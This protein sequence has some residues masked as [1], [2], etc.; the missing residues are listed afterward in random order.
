MCV[1][2][3][4]W[5]RDDGLLNASGAPIQAAVNSATAGETIFVWNGS[6]TENV[7][8]TKQITLRGE[9][10]DE[11]TV[12]AAS[13]SNHIF[14]VTADYVNIS[15]FT[16]TGATGTGKAGI[17]LRNRKHC[18]ISENSCSNNYWGICLYDSS[19]DN[20]LLGNNVSLNSHYGIRILE[21]SNNTLL[22]NTVHSNSDYGIHLSYSSDNTLLDNTV[23]SNDGGIYLRSLSN[24]NTLTSNDVSSNDEYGIN[25]CG[26]CNNTVV[27]NTVSN[28]RFGIVMYT[29]CNN[30]ML[31][32]NSCSN[33]TYNGIGLL[34]LNNTCVDNNCSNNGCG[35]DV[36]HSSSSTATGNIVLN[37]IDGIDVSYSSNNTLTNNTANLNSH[38]GIEMTSSINNTLVNNT[39]NSNTAYGIYLQSSSNNTLTSNDFSDNKYGIYLPGSSS[40]TLAN[41][42]VNSN[43]Y[44]GIYL[45]YSSNYNLVYNNYFNNANNAYDD[46]I[47][48]WNITKT[49][50]TNIIG[51]PFLGGNY[52]SDY[53]GV[54]NTGDGLGDTMLPYSSAGKIQNSGDYHPLVPVAI[55]CD[56]DIYVNEFGWWRDGGTFTISDAPIQAAVD[57]ANAGEKICVAAGNY[58]ENVNVNKQL[59][60]AGECA[61]RVT[62]I[63]ADSADHVFF[64]TAGSVNISGFTA[65]GTGF[66]KA[67]IYLDNQTFL[68]RYA[69]HCNISDNNCSKNYRGIW[70]YMS[71]DNT[72]ANNTANSNNDS[73]IYL[74]TSCNNTLDCN[75]ASN[76][77]YGIHL[78][79]SYN[80]MLV[81]NNASSNTQQG[82]H[83]QASSNN[84]MFTGN[85]YSNNGN[86]GIYLFDSSNNTFADN[87]CSNNGG[88][89][90]SLQSSCSNSC[91][92]TVT[93]NM[94]SNNHHGIYLWDASNNTLATNAI[95]SSD[96]YGIHL[97]SSS[98]NDVACNLMQNNTDCG[99]Y[100]AS[101]STGNNI[102]WN[103]IVANGE[104][105]TDGSYHYQFKN[106]QSDGVDAINNFWGS[107]MNNDTIDANIYEMGSAVEFYP[108]E[109][110]PVPC[111]PA[112]ISEGSSAFT[113]ADALI[114][115]RI[116]VGSCPF[117]SHYDVDDDG[118]V[119]SL[120]ALIIA[121]YVRTG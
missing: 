53:A 118:Q 35:I 76:N 18:N 51:G 75:M 108:F 30:N 107:G 34:G 121:T 72:L 62:V 89:G 6:Y 4:G 1:N 98:D 2:Q 93:G 97:Y 55:P 100:L 104:L 41:N 82:V 61:D 16:A 99:I 101:G 114:A 10:A 21:S 11:V 49:N 33:N 47:N 65:T 40:N 9:D 25:L 115:L 80:N 60:L 85:S 78:W 58:T 24:Y 109:T 13:S 77:Y 74:W 43:E 113:T 14:E 50:G 38:C 63:A 103:N 88:N 68:D 59:T 32:R 22:G 26:S 20:T 70:L 48:R 91:N 110:E 64:V 90:I 5:W 19:N 95:Y 87:N 52:W 3:S 56:G 120:D 31:K 46:G 7:Y 17:Y 79:T 67:G 83:L 23:H 28:N 45:F 94:V 86:D 106:S 102:T 57:D 8:I 111:A 92:N 84:N 73:G 105:Q 44:H 119:T 12:T 69:D 117:D 27:D 54:D 96:L 36:T 112:P 39:V 42:T 81:N 37:N 116:A 29:S 71:R 15:G 66:G